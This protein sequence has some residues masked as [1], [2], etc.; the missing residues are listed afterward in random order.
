MIGEIIIN[1]AGADVALVAVTGA[2]VVVT[3]LYVWQTHRL[4]EA[5]T[6]PLVYLDMEWRD[7]QAWA[8]DLRIL[9]KNIGKSPALNIEFINVKNDFLFVSPGKKE[10]QH[11]KNVWFIKQG[12]KGLAPDREITLLW[13]TKKSAEEIAKRVEVRFTY[14]NAR[15]KLIRAKYCLDFP[16]Y[17][18][19]P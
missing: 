1:S 7:V 10:P 15:G 19:I 2:L 12:L 14:K 16:A 18:E 4:V 11:F 13:M 6:N 3:A 9:V 8:S 17:M 5:Q